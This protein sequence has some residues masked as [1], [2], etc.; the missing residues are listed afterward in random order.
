MG[1]LKNSSLKHWG[2][3]GCQG[4]GGWIA[5]VASASTT[6][7]LCHANT[8]TKTTHSAALYYTAAT[9]EYEMLYF[10]VSAVQCKQGKLS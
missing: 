1:M 4:V 3:T 5:C 6:R 10:D 2:W 7:V 9:L 8:S